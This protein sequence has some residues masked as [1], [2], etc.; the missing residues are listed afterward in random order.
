MADNRRLAHR[1]VNVPTRA[2]GFL[3]PDVALQCPF[4]QAAFIKLVDKPGRSLASVAREMG[5]HPRTLGEYAAAGNWAQHLSALLLNSP[6]AIS[7]AAKQEAC[8]S[9]AELLASNRLAQG[10]IDAALMDLLEIDEAGNVKLRPAQFV[11]D[12]DGKPMRT[13]EGELIVL[14]PAATVAD[15]QKLQAARQ[16]HVKTTAALTGEEA[17]IRKSVAAAGAPKITLN[18]RDRMPEPVPVDAHAAS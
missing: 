13:E 1:A 3:P 7:V 11:T 17:A 2:P 4:A 10:A 9:R 8:R 15:V 5:C 14:R 12:D 18:L 16:L 6:E